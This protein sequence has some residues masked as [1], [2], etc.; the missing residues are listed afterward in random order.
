MLGAITMAKAWKTLVKKHLNLLLG[1]LREKKAKESLLGIPRYNFGGIGNSHRPS[2]RA[3]LIRFQQM[4]ARLM[5]ALAKNGT[6]H[7]MA[8]NRGM[9]LR[10]TLLD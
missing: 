2:I 5:S 4:V 1:L 6:C 7:F 8:T 3:M 10:V 9:G